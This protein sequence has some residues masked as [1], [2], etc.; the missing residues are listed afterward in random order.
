LCTTLLAAV[1]AAAQQS[2]VL[3]GVATGEEGGARHRTL[4]IAADGGKPAV[5][6]SGP[7][8][9]V[10]RRSGFWRVCLVGEWSLQDGELREWDTLVAAPA[11]RSRGRCA[12]RRSGPSESEQQEARCHATMNADLL[13]V[14]SDAASVRAH[15]ETNCG[16]HYSGGTATELISLDDRSRVDVAAVLEPSARARLLDASLRAARAEFGDLGEV[17]TV[18][19]DAQDTIPQAQ[20]LV[21]REWAIERGVGQWQLAGQTS[22]S[23]YVACGD[24]LRAFSVTGFAAPTR[25]VGHDAL[26][27]P[28][29]VLRSRVPGLVDAVSSPRGDLLVVF[30]PD[31]VFVF[32]PQAGRVGES[33]LRM[34]TPGKVVMV[35]W[36]VGR[37]VPLWTKE[38]A[39]LL[40]R[41]GTAGGSSR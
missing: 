17:D 15:E 1:P 25:L 26:A 24:D 32:V 10:P 31:S 18:M 3:L 11:T 22:C 9:L 29:E 33:A 13:F 6:A 34:P 21:Q 37:F 5:L 12:D 36:A 4:W 7:D 14:G 20:F 19:D 16:A 35:Q 8:L 40:G 30:T 27:I 38:I 41:A 39:K 23:P 28:L 2:G